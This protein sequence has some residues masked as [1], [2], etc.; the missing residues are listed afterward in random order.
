MLEALQ[1][2]SAAVEEVLFVNRGIEAE[3]VVT[4]LRGA[5]SFVD[6]VSVAVVEDS[7][8]FYLI[9]VVNQ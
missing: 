1:R 8:R 2:C 9:P 5:R 4:L 7:V 6:E 3:R